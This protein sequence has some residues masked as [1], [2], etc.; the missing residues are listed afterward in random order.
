M[1]QKKLEVL[2]IAIRLFSEKGYHSTS[3]DEIAKES[4][5]AKGSFYKHYQS[6]EDLLIDIFNLI[7]IQI[8]KD[9]TTLYS[10]EYDSPLD[11]LV[12]FI[13]TSLQNLLVSVIPIMSSAIFE[14]SLFKNKKIHDCAES[15]QMEMSMLHRELFLDLYGEEIQDYIWDLSLLMKSLVIQYMYVFRDQESKIDVKK[16]S[17]FIGTTIDIVAKGLAERKPESVLN[18]VFS[19]GCTIDGDS[20]FVKGRKQR[21]LLKLMSEQ[22]QHLKLDKEE[23][24][25]YQKTISLLEKEIG[26]KEPK[27]FLVKALIT[28]LQSLPELKEHCAEL[29]ELLGT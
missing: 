14:I 21:H 19:G 9:L 13:S 26:Q 20:P 17:I 28:Y 7:P 1:E 29:R 18:G 6:K 8:K 24:E 4:G 15:I 11:K 2:P 25:E 10:K 5:M 22:I 16:F 12:D 3:V 27:T 23:V